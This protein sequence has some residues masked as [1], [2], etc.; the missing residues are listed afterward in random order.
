MAPRTRKWLNWGAIAVGVTIALWGFGAVWNGS[1]RL[2]SVENCSEYNSEELARQG[3]KDGI[4][5]KQLEELRV[6]LEVAESRIDNNED[7][8]DREIGEIR[9]QVN[10]I[11]QWMM[12]DRQ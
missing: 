8:M 5:E 4:L 1:G 9:F 11:Y 2:T 10:Q 7:R 6:R 3:E 12:E